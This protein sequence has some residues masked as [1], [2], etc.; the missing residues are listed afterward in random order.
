VEIDQQADSKSEVQP[1]SLCVL[2]VR[3]RM[4]MSLKFDG[5]FGDNL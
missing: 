3:R 2:G 1:G 4:V 5:E